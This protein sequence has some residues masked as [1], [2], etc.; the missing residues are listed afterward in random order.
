M[1]SPKTIEQLKKEPCKIHWCKPRFPS[2][3]YTLRSI[4][5]KCLEAVGIPNGGKAV[6]NHTI[7]PE[8]GDLVHCNDALCTLNG[9][10]KQVKSFDGEMMIV[11]TK[12]LDASKD[13]EFF[14]FEYYGVVEMVFDMLGNIVYRRA[15]NAQK[16]EETEKAVDRR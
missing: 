6:I 14:C 7:L 9:Y 15:N 13:F 10:I 4:S 2:H 12:Y 1:K 11:G 3:E 5:G 8:V 16:S